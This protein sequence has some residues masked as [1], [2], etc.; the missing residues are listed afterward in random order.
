MPTFIKR[1]TQP[2]DDLKAISV[3]ISEKQQKWE[4]LRK[5]YHN[6]QVMFANYLEAVEFPSQHIARRRYSTDAADAFYFLY[7]SKATCLAHIDEFRS[8][9]AGKLGGCP[10]CGL[11]EN[12]TLDHYLPRKR[13]AFPEF[14]ILSS[15]LVPACSGCQNKKGHSYATHKKKLVTRAARFKP[16]LRAARATRQNCYSSPAQA[17]KTNRA[18]PFRILHPYIDSFLMHPV[19]RVI[20]DKKPGTFQVRASG[21]LEKSKRTQLDLHLKKLDVST[22]SGRAVRAA[23]NSI[24][25]DL[26]IN[27]ITFDRNSVLAELPRL[28]KSSLE[29]C[30]LAPNTIEAAYVRSLMSQPCA[31]DD[32]IQWSRERVEPN[33]FAARPVIL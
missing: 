2:C 7:D 17:K 8:T 14:S 27:N 20:P 3:F 18:L 16:K 5:E 30:G 29:R 24:I 6:L 21:G 28:L 9:A 19:I 25:R 4:I 31:L 33:V 10:Y 12:I 15:N 26:S 22:R 32:L 11:P 13:K 23:R 1:R